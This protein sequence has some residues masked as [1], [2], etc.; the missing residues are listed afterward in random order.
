M[1]F[2][3]ANSTYEIDNENKKVRRL[4][5][6]TEATERQGQDGDWKSFAD[7]SEITL[8]RSVLVV[9][10]LDGSIPATVTSPV[11]SIH[12]VPEN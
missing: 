12:A 8:G 10:A 4:Y 6:L 5:G 11:K 9:W 3:T 7:I 2:K 1:I